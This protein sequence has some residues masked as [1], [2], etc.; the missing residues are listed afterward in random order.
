MSMPVKG[1][2]PLRVNMAG[3]IPIIFAQSLL[4]LPAI[5]ASFFLKS[6]TAWVATSGFEYSDH[7]WRISRLVLAV[8]LPWCGWIYFLLYRCFVC[9]TKLWREPETGR[10]SNSWCQ[11]GCAYPA[12]SYPCPPPDY[13][14]W[15][16]VPWFRRHHAFLGWVDPT[17]GSK[18]WHL[19]VSSSG[20]L[21]VVGVVRDTFFNI[22]A[23]LKLHGYEDTLLVR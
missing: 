19:L 20:L 10:C 7:L 11:P 4:T 15:G 12:L 13:F 3:M 23:E 21:I 1:T 5:I 17:L 2:L 14:P 16:F 18:C 6:Q 9:P 8:L 22:N